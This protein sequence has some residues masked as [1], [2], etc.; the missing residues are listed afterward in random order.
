MFTK[1]FH[2]IILLH[3]W[4]MI[5]ESAP[6]HKE[7][8]HY[9]H[10][11]QLIY[12]VQSNQL[13][14]GIRNYLLHFADLKT[15]SMNIIHHSDNTITHCWYVPHCLCYLK[16]RFYLVIILICMN[17][18]SCYH[19]IHCVK[20]F[21]IE[22]LFWTVL[23]HIWTIYGDYLFHNEGPNHIESNP[24]I[25]KADQWVVSISQ[26]LSSRKS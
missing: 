15:I 24:L 14:A 20:I 6:V 12:L 5:L 18:I 7:C 21:L 3:S 26:R 2:S 22:S 17:W 16:R 9:L 13:L 23:S 8:S 25:C 10:L 1:C 11:L 4:H 19:I